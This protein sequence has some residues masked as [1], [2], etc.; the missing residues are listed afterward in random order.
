MSLRLAKQREIRD[1]VALILAE[2]QHP[3]SSCCGWRANCGLSQQS[4]ELQRKEDRRTEL[5]GR[6]S[7]RPNFWY[8]EVDHVTINILFP[9]KDIS[10]GS[11]N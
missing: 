8:K 10:N 5:T 3:G 2:T 6:V 4:A 7:S 1:S 11:L 9:K